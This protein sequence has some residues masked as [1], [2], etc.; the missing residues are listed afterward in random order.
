ME[1]VSLKDDGIDLSGFGIIAPLFDDDEETEEEKKDESDDDDEE[2]ED[3]FATDKKYLL[4]W[5]DEKAL[6]RNT[7]F[8]SF[9]LAV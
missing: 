3:V 1:L 4:H 2:D 8:Q 5:I 9:T 6:K 7:A